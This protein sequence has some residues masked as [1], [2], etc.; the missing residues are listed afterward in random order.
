MLIAWVSRVW[1]QISLGW[2]VTNYGLHEINC[3]HTCSCS[4]CKL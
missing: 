4:R 1:L 2:F 3:H